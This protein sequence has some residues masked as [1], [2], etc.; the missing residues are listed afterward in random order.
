MGLL[1][2]TVHKLK[3][4]S[5]NGGHQ[6][7]IDFKTL[8]TI[9]L[10]LPDLKEELGNELSASSKARYAKGVKKGMAKADNL[11]K[12]VAI[13]PADKLVE[14]YAQLAIDKSEADF[15]SILNIRVCFIWLFCN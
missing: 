14:T 11:I 2:K 4:P 10:Q 15:R 1:T 13:T 8:S 5:T 3:S 7:L 9:L 6:L 12:L